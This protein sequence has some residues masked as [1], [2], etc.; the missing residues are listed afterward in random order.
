[1]LVDRSIT[2]LCNP[3]K[4]ARLLADPCTH[5]SGNTIRQQSQVV[6]A[7]IELSGQLVDKLLAGAA[8]AV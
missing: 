8:A 1:M 2:K 5:R 7:A 4:R 3:A 6:L